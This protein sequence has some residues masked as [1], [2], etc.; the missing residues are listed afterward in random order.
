MA[1]AADANFMR[2]F[3]ETSLPP[4]KGDAGRDR[5]EGNRRTD[6]VKIESGGLRC[7]RRESK[8]GEATRGKNEEEEEK[9]KTQNTTRKEGGFM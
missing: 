2:L 3:N 8:K 9:K 6:G 7:A 5:A 4:L 1:G